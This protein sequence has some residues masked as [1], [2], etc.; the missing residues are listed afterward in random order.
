MSPEPIVERR[1]AGRIAHHAR[2]I[3]SGTDAEGFNFAEETDTISVSKQGV[4][5]RTSYK[6]EIGQEV[7]V[8]TKDKN[9]V[10]Q[11]QIVW[12]GKPGTPNDGRIGMEWLEPS[13]FWGIPL[14]SEDWEKD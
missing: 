1:R 7:S 11:F 5:V 10:A 12:I 3:L 6:M 2:I 8:R 13:R 4:A 14:P 9:R